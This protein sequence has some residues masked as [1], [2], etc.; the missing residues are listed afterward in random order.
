VPASGSGRDGRRPFAPGFAASVDRN[1]D[2]S[3]CWLRV[4]GSPTGWDSLVQDDFTQG[5]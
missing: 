2:G 4:P 3:I 5:H 1:G